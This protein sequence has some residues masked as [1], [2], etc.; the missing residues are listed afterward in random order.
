M[1][2]FAYAFIAMTVMFLLMLFGGWIAGGVCLITFFGA[3]LLSGRF[4]RR[5][6]GTR[7]DKEIR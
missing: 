5:E 6:V 4:S 3:C 2:R 7:K 1:N